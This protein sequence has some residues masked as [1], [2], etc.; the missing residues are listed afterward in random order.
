[1]HSE[2]CLCIWPQQ[3]ALLC[4]WTGL[5]FSSTHVP[6]GGQHKPTPVHKQ[7]ILTQPS[8]GPLHN[9][10]VSQP[11]CLHFLSG[12]SLKQSPKVKVLASQSCPT[13]LWPPLDWSPPGSSVHRILQA[14]ILEWVAIPFSRGS[15]LPKGQTQVSSIAGRFFTSEPLG[16]PLVSRV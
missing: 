5:F 3:A 7:G 9:S 12:W 13:L 15:S 2:S 1:M 6:A 14:Q 10:C 4:L 16:K 11:S 8:L